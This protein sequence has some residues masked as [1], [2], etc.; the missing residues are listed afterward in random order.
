[1]SSSQTRAALGAALKRP[2]PVVRILLS[3]SLEHLRIPLRET[4]EL[5]VNVGL[6]SQQ[7]QAHQTAQQEAELKRLIAGPEPVQTIPTIYAVSGRG[8]MEGAPEDQHMLRDAVRQKL[9][10]TGDV[11]VALMPVDATPPATEEEQKEASPELLEA[12]KQFVSDFDIP[13][14]ESMEALQEYIVRA[15]SASRATA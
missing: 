15:V 14:V 11:V 9:D 7:L 3:S 13:V 1:M 12:A 2:D 8:L 4:Q 6:E 10:D 5:D